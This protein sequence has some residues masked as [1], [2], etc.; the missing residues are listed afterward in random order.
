MA[1]SENINFG[2][3]LALLSSLAYNTCLTCRG[4]CVFYH[5]DMHNSL[6][7]TQ[8]PMYIISNGV[9]WQAWNFSNDNRREKR[10]KRLQ[11][12]S[13]V[14]SVDRARQWIKVMRRL[15]FVSVMLSTVRTGS[16]Q[17]TQPTTPEGCSEPEKLCERGSVRWTGGTNTGRNAMQTNQTNSV[18]AFFL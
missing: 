6:E 14:W 12:D 1:N 13:V 18:H 4:L 8:K 15:A 10:H 3:S 2:D 11:D 5:M 7:N 9:T 17:D 16:S